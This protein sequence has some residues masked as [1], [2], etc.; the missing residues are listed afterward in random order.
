[1]SFQERFARAI[2]RDYN[3]NNIVSRQICKC[4]EHKNNVFSELNKLND[5]KSE[6]CEE[7]SICYKSTENGHT[8]ECGHRF[9]VGCI[10]QWLTSNITGGCPLCRIS[11]EDMLGMKK[12]TNIKD[13]NNST[14]SSSSELFPWSSMQEFYIIRNADNILSQSRI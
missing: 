12:V 1:M 9:H 10:E 13:K 5:T 2:S 4:C 3:P 7:C 8:F 14:I 11:T 6:N